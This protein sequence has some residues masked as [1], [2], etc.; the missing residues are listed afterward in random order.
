M[1]KLNEVK[2]I[3]MKEDPNENDIHESTYLLNFKKERKRSINIKMIVSII[4]WL[5]GVIIPFLTFISFLI[6]LPVKELKVLKIFY[7]ISSIFVTIMHVGIVFFMIN[8]F[9]KIVD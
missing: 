5:L 6:I 2:I 4:F 9:D 7:F 3:P 8:L 1:E